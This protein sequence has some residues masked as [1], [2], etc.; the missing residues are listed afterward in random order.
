MHGYDA[1]HACS[2]LLFNS[3][4][5]GKFRLYVHSNGEPTIFE[6][7]VICHHNTYNVFI[8]KFECLNVYLFPLMDRVQFITRP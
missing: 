1:V 7:G 6:D 2:D 8:L 3:S 5:K 4:S